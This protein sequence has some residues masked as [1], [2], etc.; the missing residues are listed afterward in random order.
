MESKCLAIAIKKSSINGKGLFA[1]RNF[2]PGEKV[3]D[4]NHNCDLAIVL[5]HSCVASCVLKEPIDHTWIKDELYAGPEGIKKGDEITLD[6]SKTRWG[7][8]WRRTVEKVCGCPQCK[9]KAV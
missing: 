3:L 5:N 2:R 1:K 6:Y 4:W 9:S 8:L 7:Q